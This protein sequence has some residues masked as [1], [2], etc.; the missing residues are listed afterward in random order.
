MKGIYIIFT[1]ILSI[2]SSS[3]DSFKDEQKQ[4]PHVKQ[5]YK[6]KGSIVNKL[7][8]KNS[9][10]TENL[11][12]YLR[13]FK[14]E[15]KIELWAK[16]KSDK[17]YKLIKEFDICQT[18][19]SIGPKREQGDMQIPEGFYHIDT[20]NPNSNY[21]L[22][23]GINYPNKSDEILGVKGNPGGNIYIHGDC[24]TIGCLP[25]TDDKIKEL[26]IFCVE[27]KDSGQETIPVNI[28]PAK[29]SDKKYNYLIKKHKSNSD[30]IGLWSDL[31]LGYDFFNETKTLPSIAFLDN[32]RH[33]VTK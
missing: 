9:I 8:S 17:T 33:R 5:A 26:Y 21:Y 18:S 23:L 2:S 32:G 16:N 30:K 3:L 29:L 24:V 11:R 12:I 20:F 14:L 7:L 4:F 31:K 13:A 6:D 22:S 19:G 10:K 28:F 25:I 15:K 27:A 1:L